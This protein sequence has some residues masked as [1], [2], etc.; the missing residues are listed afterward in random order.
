MDFKEEFYWLIQRSKGHLETECGVARKLGMIPQT[1]NYDAVHAKG[2]L[3]E[4]SLIVFELLFKIEKKD[5]GYDGDD[6]TEAIFK[7]LK[8]R[9]T[10]SDPP[11]KPAL[12]ASS[13][14]T[15][16]FYF[17]RYAA[18]ELDA[19][20]ELVRCGRP[21]TKGQNKEEMCATWHTFK[22][23]TID[24]IRKKYGLGGKKQYKEGGVV[25][26]EKRDDLMQAVHDELITV[27]QAHQLLTE[28][29][30]MTTALLR[31]GKKAINTF[32]KEKRCA[33]KNKGISV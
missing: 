19:V 5:S 32:F 4:L 22:G 33:E 11:P 14:L 9:L 20:W 26:K 23:R 28:D 15:E 25:W 27:S 24:Y 3:I 21:P 18:S 30:E 2:K 16:L 1:L 7:G 10:E 13:V 8:R 6:L 17:D 31:Q 12:E 29:V